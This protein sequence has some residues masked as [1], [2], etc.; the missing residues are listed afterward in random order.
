MQ[1]DREGKFVISLDFELFWGVRDVYEF[2]DYR[3]HI[4]GVWEVVP[5]TLDMFIE[6]GINATWATVGF[7]FA[8]SY[9]EVS[10]MLPESLP[11]YTDK[12]LSPYVYN[13]QFFTENPQM[14]PYHFAPSLIER[15][16]TTKGQEIGSHT[17][18][19]YYCQEL[20]Q[21]FFG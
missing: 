15:I 17:F 5:K 9:D 2:I 6:H 14:V 3:D 1:K 16:A 11:T 20:R 10:S 18:S 8:N 13:S 12:G 19:H 4:A 7:L 21:M